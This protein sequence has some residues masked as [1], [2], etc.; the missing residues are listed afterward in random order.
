MSAYWIGSGLSRPK[1]A[2]T[3]ATTSG[4]ALRPAMREAGSAPGVAKKIRNTRMLMPSMTKTIWAR[5]RMSRLSMAAEPELGPGI[6]R[7]AH[8]V[9][10]DVEGQHR[11][12][13]GDARGDRHHR[14][15]IDQILPVLDDGAPA[16]VGRLH[17]DGE[18]GQRRF[19]QHVDRHH[20]RHEDDQGRHH[21]GQDV[22]EQ[23]AVGGHAEP[24]GREHEL[25]FLQR[26]DLAADRPCHI[27]DIDDADDE[28]GQPQA[29][30]GDRRSARCR[31]PWLMSTIESE[32]ASR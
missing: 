4:E 23:D 9:A 7:I 28:D 24:D 22:A 20:Q 16:R 5:R 10:Q 11:E 12:H 17:A 30:G 21:I 25:A 2:R 8:P 1:L 31:S 32:I 13:D 29:A 14:A 19:R 6:E 27:G 15:G 3:A 26:Q 18:E